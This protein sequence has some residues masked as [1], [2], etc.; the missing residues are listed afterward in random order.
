M[1]VRDDFYQIDSADDSATVLAWYKSRVTGTWGTAGTPSNV[2][3]P[4]ANGVRIQ[5]DTIGY[6]NEPVGNRPRTVICL[7]RI[8]DGRAD[9]C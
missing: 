3:L 4:N 5:I 1:L 9:P 2:V 8:V 6:G 7:N